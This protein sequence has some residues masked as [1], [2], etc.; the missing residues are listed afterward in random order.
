MRDKVGTAVIWITHDLGVIASLADR[1]AVMYLGRFMEFGNVDS[2]YE[3]PMHPYTRTLHSAVPVPDPIVESTRKRII[4]EGDIP[5]PANPPP[6]CPFNTL[7][8][9]AQA[10]CVAE[11]PEW[12][13][14]ES[15]HWVACHFVEEASSMAIASTDAVT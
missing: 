5:S 4:L 6:G 10:R 8:P 7:C 1:V 12:R 14:V 13:E 15:E 3:N 2:V 9:I 11:E